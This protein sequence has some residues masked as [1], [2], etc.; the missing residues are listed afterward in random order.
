MDN[1]QPQ[2]AA[3]LQNFLQLWYKD[4]ASQHNL[5]ITPQ[6][7]T[8]CDNEDLTQQLDLTPILTETVN[9]VDTIIEPEVEPLT[10]YEP[11]TELVTFNEIE[12]ELTESLTLQIK[13]ENIRQIHNK[14]NQQEQ[15]TIISRPNPFLANTWEAQLNRILDR[16]KE[17]RKSKMGYIGLLEAHYYLGKTIMNNLE[18]QDRIRMVI[19]Q[20][21]GE[22]KTRDIWKGALRLREIFEIKLI[23]LLYQTKKL[24]ITQVIRLTETEFTELT[25]VFKV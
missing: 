11:E 6:A 21:Y 19:R 16:F 12:S 1:L 7:I 17:I 9:S 10:F 13:S 18:N 3:A 20:Q 4:P 22:R 15:P 23:A 24:S 8:L 14:L 5:W 25:Q 2:T